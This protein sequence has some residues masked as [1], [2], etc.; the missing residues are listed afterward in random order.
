VLWA[1]HGP[2]AKTDLT[3]AL[4]RAMKRYTGMHGSRFIL[5]DWDQKS[6]G[7]DKQCYDLGFSPSEFDMIDT[8]HGTPPGWR[9][10]LLPGDKHPSPPAHAYV[11]DL[12]A[13][14]LA[15]GPEQS[16]TR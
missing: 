12:L 1:R 14:D 6:F 7:H 10:W 8:R 2:R 3:L 4:V 5:V 11:A 13:R 16:P 9:S 15:Q